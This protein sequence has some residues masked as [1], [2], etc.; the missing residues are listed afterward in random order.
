VSAEVIPFPKRE[1]KPGPNGSD[2]DI[3]EMLNELTVIRAKVAKLRAARRRAAWREIG[4]YD[5]AS[6]VGHLNHR[7]SANLP[8]VAGLAP[9]GMM[10]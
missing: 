3:I 8:E 7:H 9:P 2:E 5:G 1:L 6:H 10:R 4:R